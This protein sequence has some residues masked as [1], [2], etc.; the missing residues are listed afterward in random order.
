MT[1]CN[2]RRAAG[3]R[4]RGESSQKGERAKDDQRVSD[5]NAT[6]SLRPG[7]GVRVGKSQPASEVRPS[8]ALCIVLHTNLPDELVEL[9]L[10]DCDTLPI[11]V[12]REFE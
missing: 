7:R 1:R 3:I 8:I 12:V 2:R 11:W 5:M 10:H 9:H 6:F 4:R